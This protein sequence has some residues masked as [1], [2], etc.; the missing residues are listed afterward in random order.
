[1]KH[2]I[3][4]CMGSSCY[5]RGNNENLAFIEEFVEQNNIS[6]KIDLSGARCEDKCSS[7]PNIIIDNKF[8]KEVNID[9]LKE[10]ME[11]IK[12]DD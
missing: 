11:K 6:A 7:G 1:M 4:I 2:E 8:Y 5:A 3:T 10:I 9:K 12:N